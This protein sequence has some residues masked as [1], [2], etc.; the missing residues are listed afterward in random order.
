MCLE[1]VYPISF[2]N[3]A[4]SEIIVI[5]ET[6]KYATVYT[7]YRMSIKRKD[8]LTPDM[9]NGMPL[10]KQVSLLNRRIHFYLQT[11]NRQ[12]T[13][14]LTKSTFSMMLLFRC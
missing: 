4:T 11:N 5:F 10:E 7:G 1:L 9:L 12:K 3:S 8:K 14:A 13:Y 6:K 2:N